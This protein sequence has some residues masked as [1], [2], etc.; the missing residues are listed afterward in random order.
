VFRRHKKQYVFDTDGKLLG[1]FKYHRQLSGRLVIRAQYYTKV[2][3]GDLKNVIVS[4][5]KKTGD[6]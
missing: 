5:L 6:I 2:M 4:E 1:W 3:P